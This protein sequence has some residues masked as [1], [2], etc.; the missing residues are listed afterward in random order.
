MNYN[1]DM[2]HLVWIC[3]FLA[4]LS[5][6]HTEA[7]SIDLK[8]AVILTPNK[9]H[10]KTENVAA[11]MLQEEI[12]KRTGLKWQISGKY[13]T[14]KPAIAI[15]TCA[16]NELTDLE[17]PR[18]DGQDL[19]EFKPE[20]YRICVQ[21]NKTVRSVVWIIGADARGVLFGVG[22]LLRLLDCGP[23]RASLAK[24]T[25][26]VTSPAY[27]IRGHQL[28]Y[29]ARANSYD[30]WNA[31]TYE[32]YIRDL[33]IFGN[34]CI[35]NI[36]FQD[37]QS[38]PHMTIPRD[39]MNILLSK[40]CDRY[41]L[42]YWVW[43]PVEFDLNEQSKRAA[44]LARHESFYKACPRLNAVFVPGGDPG[45]NH[46]RLLLP[47]LKD[48]GDRLI[49]QHPDARVWL[50]LQGFNNEQVEYV[51]SYI[52]EHKPDWLGGL[53]AG[54]SS[55]PIPETRQRL[56]KK[57]R[58]RHY[59]DITHT[60]RCQ[61][62]VP[63]W[64]PAFSLTLGRECSNPRPVSIDGL[65]KGVI[66][67]EASRSNCMNTRFQSSRNRSQ[68]HPGAHSGLPQPTSGPWS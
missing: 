54:P 49:A 68:S 60:V 62:P 32:Q 61:Y 37:E 25:D 52:N 66:F 12:Q 22:R 51:Y 4:A 48:I 18:R 8:K 7:Q 20:G 44:E 23:G 39:Q 14:G 17:V 26:I 30:A 33:I 64:D 59:P 41:D 2:M 28:G 46:P 42:D 34:N 5:V 13:D 1:H 35:E 36:P 63:W 50:S 43:T 11:Q 67:P 10:S 27:P 16:T 15:A 53:V 55:P 45:A 38:S 58:L 31:S 47:F 24:T 56:A 9:P 3:S 6:Q 57:Y 19:P 21:Q 29:R 65:G 40:I